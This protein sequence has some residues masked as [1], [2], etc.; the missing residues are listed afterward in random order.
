MLQGARAT[1][2]IYISIPCTAELLHSAKRR[3]ASPHQAR[4]R[5]ITSHAP[6]RPIGLDIQRHLNCPL[7]LEIGISVDCL[8]APRIFSH[9]PL[10]SMVNVPAIRAVRGSRNSNCWTSFHIHFPCECLKSFEAVAIQC[11]F[12]CG[13]SS[14]NRSFLRSFNSC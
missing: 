7:F 13:P 11:Y 12:L 1:T 9:E 5:F 8:A 10:L 3:S 6:S 2:Q 4:W 14:C